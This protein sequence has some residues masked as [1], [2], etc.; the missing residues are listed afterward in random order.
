MNLLKTILIFLFITLGATSMYAQS[1]TYSYTD[2]CTGVLK[3]ISVPI[4]GS[5]AVSYYGEIQSFTYQQIIGGQ[6]EQWT[7]NVFSQFGNNN[8]CSQLVGLPTAVTI[9]QGTVYN[10]IGIIN[11][12][13]TLS[14][15]AGSS[16]MLSGTLGMV[17]TSSDNNKGNSKKSKNSPSNNNSNGTS[18]GS[19]N[20]STNAGTGQNSGNQ[21]TNQNNSTNGNNNTNS[22]SGNTS[23]SSN[24]PQVPTNNQG[25]EG[26][27]SGTSSS[28]PPSSSSNSNSQGSGSGPTNQQQGEQQGVAE[29]GSGQTNILG[30]T[31]NSVKNESDVESGASGSKKE[32]GKPTVVAS[33]DFVGFN[34]QNSEV[35][36]GLKATGGYTSLRW[37][38]QRAHGL[39]VDY[40]SAQFG[41]SVTGFY[42]WIKPRQTT[43]L[44]GTL[45]LG[46]EGLGSQYGTIAFG[47]MRTFKGIPKFKA[48]YMATAS[49]GQVYKEDFIGTAA[50]AG[51]MYDFKIGKRVDI[52]LM[53]LFIYV[54]YMSY[55]N[56]I[57]LKS[58]YVVLPSIGTNIGVTK[59]F[60]FNI[61]AGGAWA[62]KEAALNYTITCGTRLLI[63]Q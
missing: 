20:Q 44:S 58:P 15:L 6:L 5:V 28:N 42:A 36:K 62:I 30:G 63:G 35:T 27:S 46:F 51:G 7:N 23:G 48:V 8:P 60:K 55:Y 41:P 25:S 18:T 4:N 54:P 45:T 13:S 1:Y 31:T 17:N 39:L 43:L 32:G 40:T 37:D 38:G 2:P 12:L 26:Q 16:N 61:N 9:T 22:N 14:D 10:T 56:D 24:S 34:F 53:S 19:N 57:L 29:E 49:V 3:Q 21:S 59:R 52:K 11:S 47:Q 33:S 50:I